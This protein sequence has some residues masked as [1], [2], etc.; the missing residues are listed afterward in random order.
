MDPPRVMG[1][2]GPRVGCVQCE[3]RSFYRAGPNHCQWECA[4]GTKSSRVEAASFPSPGHLPSQTCILCMK[5]LLVSKATCRTT[6][7]WQTLPLA[8]CALCLPMWSVEEFRMQSTSQ[9][10][11]WNSQARFTSL[12]R[13]AAKWEK[14][15]LSRKQETKEKSARSNLTWKFSL[16]G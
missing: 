8:L 13:I 14:Q 5:R 2:A 3:P 9:K 6:T 12:C 4:L 15:D 16:A 10:S 11:T 1:L 7:G